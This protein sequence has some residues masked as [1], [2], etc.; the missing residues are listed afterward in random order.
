MNI[1]RLAIRNSQFV[2]IMILIL[3]VISYRSFVNMPR[4][5]DP[6][7]DFPIYQILVVYPGTSPEDMENLIVDPIEDA[8]NEVE[9]LTDVIT[10][11]REGVVSV[12]IDGEYGIS[13]SEIYDEI[14]REINLIRPDLPDG[15]LRFEVEQI[16]PADRVNFAVFA[17]YGEDWLPFRTI[18]DFAE[19]LE[20]LAET[21]PGVRDIDI[22]GIPEQEV[23]IALDYERMSTLN[24][25]LGQ[26][27]GILKS[28]NVNVPGGEINVGDKSFSIKST[29]GYDNLEELKKDGD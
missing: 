26:V 5:E 11:I 17:I 19:D 7:V 18:R 4:A 23:R 29:G 3:M 10:D 20:D 6:Q 24:I 28:N 21:I 27:V 22:D 16:K 13:T 9:N 2:V 25:S 14:L 1:T 12:I 8:L 15:I